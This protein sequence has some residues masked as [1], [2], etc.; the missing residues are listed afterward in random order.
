MADARAELHR[1]VRPRAGRAVS[2]VLAVVWAAVFVGAAFGFPPIP[3]RGTLDSVAFVLLAAAGAFF[4]YRLGAVAVLPSESGLVVRNIVGRTALEWPEV[5]EVRFDRDSTWGKLDLA[6]GTTMNV[7]GIQTA[8]GSYA[9]QE[10]V[11][12][13]TLLELHSREGG[14]PPAR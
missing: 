4:L 2:Y 1:P 7:L 11:R 10:A 3:G 8:D 6:D 14:G 5:V 12:L 9:Q 13:A